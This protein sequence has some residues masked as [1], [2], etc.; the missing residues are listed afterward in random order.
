MRKMAA[1]N[2]V[3]RVVPFLLAIM[4][5]GCSIGPAEKSA[6]RTYLLDPELSFKSTPANAAGTSLGTLL[7]TTPRA[8]AG[9]DTPR[10]V[11]LLRPHEVSYYA[12]NQ[13]TDSPA[14]MLAHPLVQAMESTRLWNAVVQ[15]PSPVLAGYR[16]D[17]DNLVLEQQFFSNPSRVRLALRAQL[18]DVNRQ[19]V[20]GTR[21][22]EIFEVAP[23]EDAYG[24]VVAANRATA[25]LLEQLAEWVI[26][27][28]NKIEK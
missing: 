10:M 18:I 23:S 9:F 13:W 7:V 26:T 8:Q 17:C 20:M 6:P 15:A 25:K 21:D 1:S 3:A 14:R 22:F 11:Y 24:G 4:L 19:S 5:N 28:A 12:L 27:S 16:L 2:G